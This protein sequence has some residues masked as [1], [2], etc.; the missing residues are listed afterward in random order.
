MVVGWVIAERITQ[1]LR[2]NCTLALIY[3]IWTLERLSLAKKV[4]HVAPA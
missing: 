2:F 4:Y 3:V 1:A